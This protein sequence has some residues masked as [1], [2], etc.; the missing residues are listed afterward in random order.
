M[1]FGEWR[2][3]YFGGNHLVGDSVCNGELRIA[4]AV[5][6]RNVGL[7][8]GNFRLLCQC[9]AQAK[10]VIHRRGAGFRKFRINRDS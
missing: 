9:P 3:R 10:G 7:A 2:G 5:F 8:G 6:M 4:E 1:T